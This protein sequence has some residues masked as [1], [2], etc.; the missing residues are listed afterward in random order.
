[1]VNIGQGRLG[2]MT[3]S[4][5]PGKTPGAGEPGAGSYRRRRCE[6]LGPRHTVAHGA[7]HLAVSAST[8]QCRV[9]GSWQ[10]ETEGRMSRLPRVLPPRALAAGTDPRSH[11]ISRQKFEPA[12]AHLVSINGRKGAARG[13]CPRRV[14]HSQRGKTQAEES[15]TSRLKSRPPDGV[16]KSAPRSIV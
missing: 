14:N 6:I 1:M 11:R 5:H 15:Q 9:R 13:S 16:G 2:I 8:R 7:K 12:G 3:I 10:A 4:G